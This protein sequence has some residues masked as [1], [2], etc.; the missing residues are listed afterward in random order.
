MT[1]FLLFGLCAVIVGAATCRDQQTFALGAAMVLGFAVS[2]ALYFFRFAPLDRVGPYTLIEILVAFGAMI[3]LFQRGSWALV[4]VIALNLISI[5]ANIA[6]ALNIPPNVQQI[7]AWNVTTNLCF[8]G[9][10]A[11]ATWVGL[12]NGYRAGRFD[13]W[14][15]HRRVAVASVDRHNGGEA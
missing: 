14:L 12:S 9:E 5:S 7:Y 4:A 15:P 10:C 13:R 2:N 1:L 8:V 6:L 11:F 3:A